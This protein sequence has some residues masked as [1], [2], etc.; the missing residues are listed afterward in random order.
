[1]AASTWE[2]GGKRPDG[3]SLKLLDLVK[4]TGLQAIA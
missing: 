3:P 1:M 4:A 2:L